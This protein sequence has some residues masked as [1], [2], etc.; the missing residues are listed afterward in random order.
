MPVD[1][2]AGLRADYAYNEA[3]PVSDYDR[4]NAVVRVQTLGTFVD[5]HGYGILSGFGLLADG[6]V[7]AGS[8]VLPE[9]WRV[10][11]A[12]AQAVLDKT[13]GT[14][15]YVWAVKDTT[16]ASDKTVTFRSNVT[17]VP[18]TNSFYLGVM[19]LD[20]AGAVT[21]T[22]D[23]TADR[24]RSVEVVSASAPAETVVLAAENDAVTVTVDH[25]ATLEFRLFG[26]VVVTV[27]DGYTWSTANWKKGSFDLTLT[28]GYTATTDQCAWSWT[29]WGTAW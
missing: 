7:D 17:G 13:S 4:L 9:G 6:T 21:S 19:V 24:V 10:E 23:S 26:A 2:R 18:Y 12:A 5:V 11:T 22:D 27:P 25:S 14:T 8:G 1:A 28:R 20:G 15:N 16:S 3:V 29:R